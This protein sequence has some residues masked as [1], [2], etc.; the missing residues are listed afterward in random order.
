MIDG[1]VRVHGLDGLPDL[2][3]GGLAVDGDLDERLAAVRR[4]RDFGLRLSSDSSPCPLTRGGFSRRRS[5]VEGSQ[6]PRWRLSCVA[7]VPRIGSDPRHTMS[8]RHSGGAA[9]CGGGY[10]GGEPSRAMSPGR[11]LRPLRPASPPRAARSRS[12][13]GEGDQAFHH[14]FVA[15]DLRGPSAPAPRFSGPSKGEGRQDE[16]AS[17]FKADGHAVARRPLPRRRAA[18]PRPTNPSAIIAQVEGSG[19]AAKAT[20]P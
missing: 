9:P 8:R 3:R 12:A 4:F 13:P 19:A 18:Q 14:H 11:M 1:G 17:G 5:G 15:V 10:G 16:A 7:H 2:L 6:R 20:P